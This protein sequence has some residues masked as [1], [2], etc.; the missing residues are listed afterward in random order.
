MVGLKQGS[1]WDNGTAREVLELDGEAWHFGGPCFE[2][3]PRILGNTENKS[4]WEGTLVLTHSHVWK[5]GS[6]RNSGHSPMAV[7]V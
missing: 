6:P 7:L 5:M 1:P 4:V 2:G 3:G